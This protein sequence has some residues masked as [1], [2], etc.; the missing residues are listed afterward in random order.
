MFRALNVLRDR[1]PP[2]SDCI[3]YALQRTKA[4]AAAHAKWAVQIEWHFTHRVEINMDIIMYL[5]QI[6]VY[7]LIPEN[8]KIFI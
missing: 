3:L 7:K 6:G 1:R 5:I 8:V 4:A 2:L